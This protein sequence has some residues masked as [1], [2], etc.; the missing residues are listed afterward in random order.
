[1]VYKFP[2]T[3]ILKTA[4]AFCTWILT[5]RMITS[6]HLHLVYKLPPTE[7]LRLDTYTCYTSSQQPNN[8]KHIT[9]L[10]VNQQKDDKRSLAIGIEITTNKI[11]TSGCGIWYINS[12]KHD[13]YKLPNEF[14]IKVLQ[15]ELLQATTCHWH[16]DSHKQNYKKR[17]LAF[18]T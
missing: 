16:I 9:Y 17:S 13:H 7:L 15:K 18:N 2:P 5:K 12:H 8:Y 10:N 14:V 3:E 1:M 4:L 6:G 11:I